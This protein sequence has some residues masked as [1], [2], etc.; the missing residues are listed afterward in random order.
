MNLPT[1]NVSEVHKKFILSHAH[2]ILIAIILMFVAAAVL[3]GE[4]LDM[5]D[6][7]WWWD[8]MLHGL[9]GLIFGLVGLFIMFALNQ[10]TDIRVNAA[11]VA[12]FVICFALAM[13]VLWEIYEFALDVFF[14]TTMQQWNMGSQAIVM[15]KEYQGMGLRDT[16][17]DLILATIGALVAGAVSFVAYSHKLSAV[18][19]VMRKSFPRIK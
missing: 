11:F 6:K 9:S 10:R 2:H 17:S 15:G 5:Y 13:G 3:L 19:H 12:V 18:R 7:L 14:Q 16:M 8:D 1:S 4:A